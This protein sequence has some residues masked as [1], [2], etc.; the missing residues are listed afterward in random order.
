MFSVKVAKP[1]PLNAPDV[2]AT[3]VGLEVEVEFD[4]P[5]EVLPE[6]VLPEEVLPGELLEGEDVVLQGRVLVS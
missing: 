6:G 4:L 1:V 2:D 3:L 5:E